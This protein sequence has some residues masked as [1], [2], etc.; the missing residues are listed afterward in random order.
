MSPLLEVES[1]EDRKSGHPSP[2]LSSHL[3]GVEPESGPGLRLRDL[4]SSQLSGGQ[5]QLILELLEPSSSTSGSRRRTVPGRPL[6]DSDSQTSESS[7][8]SF[9]NSASM[10]ALR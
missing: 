8:L 3:N 6:V 10:G 2:H 9:E 7:E 5:Q 1:Q 4:F